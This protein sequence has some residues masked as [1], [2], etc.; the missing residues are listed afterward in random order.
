MSYPFAVSRSRGRAVAPFIAGLLAAVLGAG[1]AAQATDV[2]AA[3]KVFR[4]MDAELRV[5]GLPFVASRNDVSEFVLRAERAIF[6]P[7]TNLAELEQMQVTSTE[8]SDAGDARRSFAVRCNRGELNVETS[9]FLAE[10]DVRG[11]TGDGR[12]YQAPWVRYNHE[13]QL[14]YT[15][16]PVMMQ[17][18]AGSFRGDGFRYYVKERRFRLIGN[19]SLV[20]G[21]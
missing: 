3:T 6:K 18:D 21:E 10:G 8:G 2:D 7:E 19:V 13:Q 5:T 12:R 1:H 16:A 11:T 20:Q 14:L 17:D 9:D 4:H 15:D